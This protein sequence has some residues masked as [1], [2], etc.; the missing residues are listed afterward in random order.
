VPAL[1]LLADE[2]RSVFAGEARREL[3]RRLPANARIRVMDAGHTLHRDRF[4]DYVAAVLD[5]IEPAR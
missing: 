5:W 3:E 4:E 1:Y 2:A